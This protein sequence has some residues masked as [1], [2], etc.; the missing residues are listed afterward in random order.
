MLSW[1]FAAFVTL[2]ASTMG[3]L[4]GFGFALIFVPM[5]LLLFDVHTTVILNIMLSSISAYVLTYIERRRVLFKL[6]RNL[7][8]ASLVG[9]PPGILLFRLA[10]VT[11]LKATV[12]IVSILAS[13]LLLAGI[14]W[15]GAEKKWS[16]FAAGGIAGFL[17]GSIGIP[18]PPIILLLGY[19]GIPKENFRATTLAYFAL[20][21]SVTF[22]L[23]I[24]SEP[25]PASTIRYGLTLLPFVIGGQFIGSHFFNKVPQK[26][27]QIVI[28][29]LIIVMSTYSLISSLVSLFE[30]IRKTG[31]PGEIVL[32]IIF[33][34]LFHL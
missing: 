17:S 34:L 32:F 10:D 2:L 9:L 13:V 22:P 21:V 23:L 11:L 26:H 25:N 18:G 8:L 19:R 4:T 14:K 20:I 3:A 5:L 27:F 30:S 6:V 33:K 28:P 24:I 29:V 12:S 16:E 7:F 1:I 31:L 15:S